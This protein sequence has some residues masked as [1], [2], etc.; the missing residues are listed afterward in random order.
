MKYR[1]SIAILRPHNYEIEVEAES[2]SDAFGKALRAW[3][4]EEVDWAFDGYVDDAYAGD[5][6]LNI[7]GTVHE[8]VDADH[9]G[10][11]IP[12]GVFIEPVA[13][14]KEPEEA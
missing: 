2:Q 8:N 14:P 7:G 5:D 4:G 12:T 3:N 13:E 10:G 11:G 9:W 6:L 1:V